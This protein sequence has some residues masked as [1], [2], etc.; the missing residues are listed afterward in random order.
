MGTQCR[1]ARL[2][3]ARRAARPP[4]LVYGQQLPSGGA[5]RR[6][7]LPGAPVGGRGCLLSPAAA[8][9]CT[10]VAEAAASV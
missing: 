2:Q 3:A 5:C 6:R 4:L 1:W 8:A 9:G 7:A 10:F